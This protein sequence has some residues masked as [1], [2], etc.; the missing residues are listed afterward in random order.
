MGSQY[1]KRYT[2]ECKW[3]SIALVD[4]SGKTVTA[5]A[6]ELGISPESLRRW[7]RQAKAHRGGGQGGE[8]TSAEREESRRLRKENR[9]QQ[10]TIEVL[11]KATALLVKENDR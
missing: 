4:S 6:W 2:E 8:L 9:E 10:Q 11:R 1:T 3:D 5:V 7:N